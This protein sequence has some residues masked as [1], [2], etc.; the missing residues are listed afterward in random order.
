ME[1]SASNRIIRA[2]SQEAVR[3]SGYSDTHRRRLEA[4]GQ[5]PK[6]FRLNPKGGGRFGASGYRLSDIEQ[7]LAE[8]G[9]EE[10]AR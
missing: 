8:R 5:F 4:D 3:L 7:W 1:T 6:R 10:G 2:C 9:R